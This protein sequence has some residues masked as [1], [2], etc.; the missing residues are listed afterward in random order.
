[1]EAQLR[2][3]EEHIFANER[4]VSYRPSTITSVPRA[5]PSNVSRSPKAAKCHTSNTVSSN[6]AH[7]AI[8]P[9]GMLLRLAHNNGVAFLQNLVN[10]NKGLERLDL[11]GKNRLPTMRRYKS[12]T[13]FQH[14]L[15]ISGVPHTLSCPPKRPP[16]I[17]G[18]T[19]TRYSCAHVSLRECM[20][21]ES[22]AMARIR[23][24]R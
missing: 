12:A 10:G 4:S 7:Q 19:C 15:L 18:P 22:S 17:C 8:N 16:T 1:M 13:I 21:V 20:S 3:E 5:P 11:V 9:I 23:Y 2:L 6:T 14:L 24:S